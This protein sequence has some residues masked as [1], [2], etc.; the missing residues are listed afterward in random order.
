MCGDA[1]QSH[2]SMLLR[3]GTSALVVALID[4]GLV[5]DDAVRLADPLSALAVVTRDITMRGRLELASGGSMTALDIQRHYLRQ[6]RTHRV[7]LPH[8][9]GRLCDVWQTTLDRLERGLDAVADRLDWAIKLTLLRDRGR[10]WG[11]RWPDDDSEAG[12]EAPRPQHF[13]PWRAE[14]CE[15]DL[16]YGQVYPSGLFDS[17]DH[18]AVLRHGVVS[19]DEVDRALTTPPAEGRARIRASVV[20]RLAHQCDGSTCT[21]DGVTDAATLRT[22]DLSNPFIE[23]EVW[24][25]QDEETAAVLV[26]RLERLVTMPASLAS[27]RSIL[28]IAKRLSA[29][30]GNAPAHRS[31]IHAVQLNNLAF[32]LRNRGRL[33][34]A[35]WLMRAAL[36]TDLA[37]RHHRHSKVFHRRNNLATVLLMQ[38]Q[39]EEARMLVTDA[40]PTPDEPYD[41][42]SIRVLTIRL[43]IALIDGE[44]AGLWLGQL[45][46]HLAIR[47]L[48]NHAEVDRHWQM[49]PVLN[50]LAPKLGEAVRLLETIVAIVNGDGRRDALE[51]IA[52]WRD[53]PAH[54]LGLA[55]PRPTRVW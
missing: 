25:G 3:I 48:L 30:R 14:M 1:N 36:A 49:G 51:A 43:V 2:L 17:L 15:I 21:W 28:A 24:R 41:L 22:L 29:S 47:P 23:T 44:P 40:W 50:A 33:E 54:T 10:K 19:A 8:W 18:A 27:T 16:R 6:A 55:W 11:R 53:T 39:V 31:V 13:D 45:K 5:D 26:S 32:G 35:E 52:G 46:T 12:M 34:E 9:A 4:A 38:G 20:T 42:T 37:E 7:A